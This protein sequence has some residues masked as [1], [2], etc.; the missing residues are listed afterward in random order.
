[1][2]TTTFTDEPGLKFDARGYSFC[3]N[4]ALEQELRRK[5]EFI[6]DLSYFD[7]LRVRGADAA[8]FLH[9]QLTNDLQGLAEGYSQLSGYCNAKGRLLC[10]FR[11]HHDDGDLLLQAHHSIIIPTL[12]RLRKYV[13]RSRVE[14]G[15]DEQVSSFGVVGNQGAAALRKMVD[16]LPLRRNE[17]VKTGGLTVICHSTESPMR[18]QIVGETSLLAPLWLQLG[19]ALPKLGSWAWASV[20]IE[21]GLANVLASTSEQFV[22]QMLNL[23][24]VGAVSFDKGCYPGQEIVAR[25]HYLG[26]LKTRMILGHVSSQHLPSPGDKIYA[27]GEEQSIGM[28][29]EA[30]AGVHGYDILA[31]ARLE[32][33]QRDHLQLRNGAAV[34]VRLGR[35]PYDLHYPEQKQA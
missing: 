9:S 27:V 35:L 16:K 17:C 6:C 32:H 19:G 24:I 7:F 28:V 25:M 2:S 5:L 31:T 29:V 14:L 18:Y 30:M 3:Q 26:K 4:P 1:M 11:I 12:E 22:P 10:I 13:L 23:D 20:D 21:Q 34:S 33:L 8:V 15:V